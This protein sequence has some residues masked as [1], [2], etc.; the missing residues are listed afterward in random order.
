MSQLR[1]Q[2]STPGKQADKTK[3]YP[4]FVER[5]GGATNT[6]NLLFCKVIWFRFKYLHAV[7]TDV[8]KAHA[9]VTIPKVYN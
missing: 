1:E 4:L 8:S 2:Y 9:W 3:I 5:F 7:D 6:E